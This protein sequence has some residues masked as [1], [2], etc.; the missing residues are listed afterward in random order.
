MI[1][2]SQLLPRLMAA[3][4]DNPELFETV[5]KLAWTRVVGSG[6]RDQVVP[7][8]LYRKTLIVAVTDAIWQRQLHRM[9]NEYVFRIN[10]ALGSDAIDAIEFRIDPATI[11][12]ARSQLGAG[13]QKL[14]P[15]SRAPIPPELIS[16]ADQ[17]SDD[18]LRQRFVRAAENC[19]SRRDARFGG[20]LQSTFGNSTANQRS[21]IDN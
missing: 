21:T 2:L 12:N 4:S 16:A 11:A 6:L 19:I 20:K 13:G 14:P 8:R 10:R 18:A 1:D 5:V 9:S 7:F 17:I 15:E 3:A